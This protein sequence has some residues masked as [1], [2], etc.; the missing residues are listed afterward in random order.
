ML[1]NLQAIKKLSPSVLFEENMYLKTKLSIFFFQWY[2]FWRF[3]M[4][5]REGWVKFRG[6]PS[7]KK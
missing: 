4:F 5:Y 6:G 1:S 3:C 2:K 7:P